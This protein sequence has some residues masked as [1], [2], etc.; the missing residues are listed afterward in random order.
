MPD[1][2]DPR[3]EIDTSQHKLPHWQQGEAWIFVTWRQTD[4]IPATKLRDWKEER[5][6]W[7]RHH[8]KPWDDATEREFQNRFL[9]QFGRWLDLSHGSCVLREPENR[10]IVT[11]ALH[12]FDGERYRL[13]SYVVMPNHIHVLFS[14]ISPHPLPRIVQS[15]K[16]HSARLINARL[17]RT[18]ESLWQPDYFDRLIRSS[19]HLQRVIKYIRNNPSGLPDS[20]F[21]LHPP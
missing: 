6:A 12:H 2:F 9:V 14:P 10:R 15:W 18:G 1:F 13:G 8:P 4:S 16:R 3:E 5:D 11:D 20:N 17:D 19:E 21:T 7:L